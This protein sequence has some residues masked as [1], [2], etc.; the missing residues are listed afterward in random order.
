FGELD[1]MQHSTGTRG[2]GNRLFG[3]WSRRRAAARPAGKS[4]LPAVAGF[5][6]AERQF[7]AGHLDEAQAICQQILTT[8]PSHVGA[9]HSLGAIAVQRGEHLDAERWIRRALVLAPNDAEA[10]SNLGISLAQQG[11]TEEALSS[12]ERAIALK[13][14]FPEAHLNL[15]F[16]LF[17][18]E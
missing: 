11:R 18:Q 3:G 1:I 6:A 16:A 14:D 13:P 7:A 17:K 8:H 2:R 15:G 9:L 4:T 5:A 10:H 12:F